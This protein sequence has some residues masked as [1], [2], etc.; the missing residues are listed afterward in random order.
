MLDNI[1]DFVFAALPWIAIGVGA[2]IACANMEK[3]G[4]LFEKWSNNSR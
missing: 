3:I 2:A 4:L 1:H